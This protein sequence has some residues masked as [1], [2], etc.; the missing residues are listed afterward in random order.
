MGIDTQIKK[1]LNKIISIE[2]SG[3]GESLNVA[4]AGSILMSSLAKK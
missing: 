4:I 3:Y 2:K 1:D